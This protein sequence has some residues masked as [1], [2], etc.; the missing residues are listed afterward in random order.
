LHPGSSHMSSLSV[1][2]TLSPSYSKL[3]CVTIGLPSL[4]DVVRV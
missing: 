3:N 1:V 2:F 4:E